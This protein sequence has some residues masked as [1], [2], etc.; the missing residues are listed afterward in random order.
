M[1]ALTN[2]IAATIADSPITALSL[3]TAFMPTSALRWTMQPCSTAPWPMW[4]SSSIDRVVPGKR[5][6]HAG[7]LHVGAGADL[8]PPEVAA[9]AGG[10]PDVAAGADDHVADQHRA[11]GA[12]TRSDRRPASRRRFHRRSDSSVL[13]RVSSRRG[14]RRARRMPCAAG[15]ARQP[16]RRARCGTSAA[17]AKRLALSH[18]SGCHDIC[19]V[20][21]TRSGCGIRIVKRPSA[22][23]SPVM[24]CGEPFG[25]V[26][27]AL[28][29]PP[30]VV[31]EAQRDQRLR[32]R[33]LRRVAELGVALAV[34]GRDRDAAAL[35]A[36]EEE[37]RR[38]LHLEQHEA[39]LELLRPVADEVRPVRGARDELVQVA[40]HLAA[41]AHAEREA[42]R[43]ARRTPRTRRAPAR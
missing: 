23:V 11:S 3:T 4:P 41:V 25:V 28:G 27:I 19:T 10:G 39:R 17:T 21:N 20:R 13:A 22:V 5:V 12:R 15:V 9:Q 1:P 38:R 16:A 37:R 24:P 43:C 29:R 7:V 14:E 18:S 36:A 34:G 6:Q 32:R 40:H 8:E 26:R 42:C 30:R 31:D 33:E 2:A 35:H